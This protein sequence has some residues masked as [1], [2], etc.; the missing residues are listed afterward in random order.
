[1]IIQVKQDVLVEEARETLNIGGIIWDKASQKIG[2]PLQALKLLEG[3][4]W[5]YLFD[6]LDLEGVHTN[7]LL[8][9]DKT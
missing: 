9:H 2:L 1:M 4:R 5:W 8:G 3:S 6:G 7:A